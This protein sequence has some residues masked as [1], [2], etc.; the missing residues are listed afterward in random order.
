MVM[1]DLEHS[2][3]LNQFIPPSDTPWDCYSH[4]SLRCHFYALQK[5][6]QVQHS[7]WGTYVTGGSQG[8][9]IMKF[10][11]PLTAPPGWTGG[12]DADYS[13]FTCVA[14]FIIVKSLIILQNIKK[15]TSENFLAI[16]VYPTCYLLFVIE[17]NN[18]IK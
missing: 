5:I 18:L 11:N 16:K 14:H 9:P 15:L 4:I 12:V 7:A 17:Y 8:K 1:L 6:T 10:L 3:S 2:F 13:R